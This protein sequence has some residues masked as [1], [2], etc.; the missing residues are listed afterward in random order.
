MVNANSLAGLKKWLR[1]DDAERLQPAD[2][3]PTG[4]AVAGAGVFKSAFWL[5]GFSNDINWRPHCG[6]LLT[7][8]ARR[9]R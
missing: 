9:V 8:D 2:G 6:L 5:R 3:S 4:A 1:R 7:K